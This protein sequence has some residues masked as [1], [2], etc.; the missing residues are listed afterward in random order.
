MDQW[1][2]WIENGIEKKI[3]KKFFKTPQRGR[4]VFSNFD[5]PRQFEKPSNFVSSFIKVK[6]PATAPPPPEAK[7]VIATGA[8]LVQ[9][10]GVAYPGT[11]S[12]ASAAAAAAAKS[13]LVSYPVLGVA[14]TVTTTKP[15]FNAAAASGGRDAISEMF[16]L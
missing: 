13:N 9:Y 16:D 8:N 1:K 4:N 10:P 3:P 2:D 5:E 11:V 15:N 12:A 14:S 7:P 6:A